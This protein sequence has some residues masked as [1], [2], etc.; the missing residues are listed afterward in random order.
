MPGEPFDVA[1]G[2]ASRWAVV[3]LP[4]TR[5]PAAS[6]CCASTLGARRASCTR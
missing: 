5:G 4:A 2:P 1:V 3:S 6:P